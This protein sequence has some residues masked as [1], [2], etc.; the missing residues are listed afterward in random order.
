MKNIFVEVN[1]S[2]YLE[3]LVVLSFVFLVGW[4]MWLVSGIDKCNIGLLDS[5][6]NVRMCE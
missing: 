5:W 6:M 2:I 1:C 4:C 3:V